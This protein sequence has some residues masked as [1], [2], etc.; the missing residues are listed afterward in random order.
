[1]ILFINITLKIRQ[2][3]VISGKTLL[4][5]DEWVL[6][7]NKYEHFQINNILKLL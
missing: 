3:P 1:M 4:F 6:Q 5:T 2:M 7:I